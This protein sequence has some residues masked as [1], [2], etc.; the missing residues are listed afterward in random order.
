MV[1]LKITEAARNAHKSGEHEILQQLLD[2]VQN[3]NKE[4]FISV[5][6]TA[7]DTNGESLKNFSIQFPTTAFILNTEPEKV[8]HSVYLSYMSAARASMG[9]TTDTSDQQIFGEPEFSMEALTFR[10]FNMLKYNRRATSV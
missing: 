3:R 6:Q 4:G 10:G 7:F 8:E 9:H 1:E 2:K 5:C